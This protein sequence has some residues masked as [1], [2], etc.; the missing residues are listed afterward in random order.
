MYTKSERGI[1]YER[2]REI[3]RESQIPPRTKIIGTVQ[4]HHTHTTNANPQTRPSQTKVLKK[5]TSK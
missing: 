2:E 5:T 4:N 3:Q 1:E